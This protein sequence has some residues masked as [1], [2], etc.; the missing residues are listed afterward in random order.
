MYPKVLIDKQTIS[1]R[2]H[3]KL[4]PVTVEKGCPGDW[5]EGRRETLTFV[6]RE[7][8]PHVPVLDEFSFL[9][10]RLVISGKS[11][12]SHLPCRPDSGETPEQ[13]LAWRVHALGDA[14]GQ[15]A[16]GGPAEVG[17]T[18]KPRLALERFCS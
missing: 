14:A 9:K 18:G 3:R 7:C 1:G 17:D 10:L 5:G 16:E 6:P 15:G 12:R 2:F 11:S 13:E 4:A 8:F